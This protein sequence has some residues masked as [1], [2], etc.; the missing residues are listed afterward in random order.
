L[1]LGSERL[2]YLNPGSFHEV[3]PTAHLTITWIENIMAHSS[4]IVG[5]ILAFGIYGSLLFCIFFGV[6][7]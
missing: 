4:D 5:I 7:F 2:F 3:E 1:L 6:P